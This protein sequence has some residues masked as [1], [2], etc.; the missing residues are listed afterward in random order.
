MITIHLPPA[1]EQREVD[2]V[3]HRLLPGV[4]GVEM[5][6]RLVL[7]QESRRMTRVARRL[8]EVDDAVVGAAGSNPL[9]QRLALGF[10]DLREY[11]APSN[12]V[13]VAPKITMP[14][15]CARSISCL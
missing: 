12:G 9:V 15:V 13:S 6:A 7:R 5:I 4:A 10:A 3:G 14:R 2:R 8:V 11:I 1:L